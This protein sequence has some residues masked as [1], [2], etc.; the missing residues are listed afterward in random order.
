M[1]KTILVFGLLITALLVLFQLGKYR[2]FEGDISSEM[3]ISI[4][5]ILF[6]GLGIYFRNRWNKEEQLP[7]KDGEID[8]AKVNELDLSKREMEVLQELVNGLSNKEIAEKLF[9]SESTTKTHVS[10]IYSKLNVNR[11]SQAILVSKE[12][13]LVK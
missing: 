6:F 7:T 12:L 1:K 9:I 3:V 5:A 2:M 10:N 11:R 8:Y 13:N 4:A